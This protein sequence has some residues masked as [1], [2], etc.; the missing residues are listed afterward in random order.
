M[1]R[2]AYLALLGYRVFLVVFALL[3]AA[4]ALNE[5]VGGATPWFLSMLFAVSAAL[6]HILPLIVP[7]GRSRSVVYSLGNAF[8]LAGMFLL[9]AGPL[10]LSVGFAVS[11]ASL[12][13]A[14]RPHRQLGRL[15]MSVLAFGGAALYFH[16][17]PRAADPGTPTLARSVLELL[18]MAGALIA[19]LLLRSIEL[20]LE[21]GEATPHWGA[22]QPDVLVEGALTVALGTTITVLARTH[23]AYL[24]LIYMQVGATWWFLQRYRARI[25]RL[26][27]AAPHATGERRRVAAA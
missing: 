25:R 2:R 11:L 17:G 10:V 18:I 1:N 6:L 23:I 20:R 13:A 12:V 21:R 5:P 3:V 26:E 27:A 15:A 8:F 22:F 4:R 9:P 14:S 19:L 16:L 7:A 24:G